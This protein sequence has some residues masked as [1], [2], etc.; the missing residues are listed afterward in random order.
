MSITSHT[1]SSDK[2]CLKTLIVVF[3]STKGKDRPIAT[4]TL[5]TVSLWINCLSFCV[6]QC[7]FHGQLGPMKRRYEN[8]PDTNEVNEYGATEYLL[9]P[10]AEGFVF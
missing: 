1:S 8:L 3:T 5:V 7:T 6:D 9:E 4:P 10:S 2:P